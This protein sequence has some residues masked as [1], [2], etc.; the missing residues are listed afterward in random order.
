MAKRHAQAANADARAGGFTPGLH[1][2][3]LMT[4]N[5]STRKS[6]LGCIQEKLAVY[7]AHRLHLLIA[8]P[9]LPLG[10]QELPPFPFHSPRGRLLAS[11][12]RGFIYDYGER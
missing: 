3:D 1:R 9:S 11:H 12:L 10:L 6:I 4:E 2:A 8:L 5:P 7:F